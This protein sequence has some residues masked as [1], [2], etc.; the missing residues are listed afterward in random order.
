MAPISIRTELNL[1]HFSMVKLFSVIHLIISL[2]CINADYSIS[3]V[4]VC[5]SSVSS[6]YRLFILSCKARF[7]V[8]NSLLT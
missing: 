5:R 7:L 3:V 2:V 6:S 4:F 8:N 1:S